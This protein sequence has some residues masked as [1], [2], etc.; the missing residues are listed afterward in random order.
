MKF[1]VEHIQVTS[2]NEIIIKKTI[3]E[4]KRADGRLNSRHMEKETANNA[5][6][7]YRL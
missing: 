3:Q 7:W 2:A 4:K 5:K 1:K 6:E